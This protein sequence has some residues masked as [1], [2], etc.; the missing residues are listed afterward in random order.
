[1]DSSVTR[2]KI[3]GKGRLVI[4]K[5]LREKVGLKEGDYVQLELRDGEIVVVKEPSSAVEAMRGALK[6]VW[7]K[8]ET[9]VKIQRKLRKEWQARAGSR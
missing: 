4:P 3:A 9:S 2:S 7:P 6:D 1:M 5:V 8:G